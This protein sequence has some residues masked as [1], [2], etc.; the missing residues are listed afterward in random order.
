M[1]FLLLLE[2]S[3]WDPNNP[4]SV[5]HLP[6][7]RDVTSDA[8]E[9]LTIA[10]EYLQYVV[11][12]IL[13]VKTCAYNELGKRLCILF[14]VRSRCYA[15]E[16]AQIIWLRQPREFRRYWL[17]KTTNKVRR[18]AYSH[19]LRQLDQM[20]GPEYT[21]HY[22]NDVRRMICKGAGSERYEIYPDPD[23]WYPH[24][25]WSAVFGS[26]NVADRSDVKL[27]EFINKVKSITPDIKGNPRVPISARHELALD[28]SRKLHIDGYEFC[29]E[30]AH[31]MWK[32]ISREK[33]AYY[34]RVAKHRYQVEF[35]FRAEQMLRPLYS[36]PGNAMPRWRPSRCPIERDFM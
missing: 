11:S 9:F 6:I 8:C 35:C 7:P 21:N 15:I 26:P 12:D 20:Y 4:D 3:E 33:R 13:R 22:I 1:Q 28:L 32:R 18:V 29:V 30:I 36:D 14:S 10:K 16:L 19:V 34:R 31:I 2:E 23:P 17:V 27:S 25:D 24:H 5:A